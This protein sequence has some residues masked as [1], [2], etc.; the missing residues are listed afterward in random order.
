MDN[1]D[2]D[3]KT[4]HDLMR[5]LFFENQESL[6]CFF[7]KENCSNLNDLGSYFQ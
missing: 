7:F 3:E 6:Q 1:S 5:G 2:S 4:R